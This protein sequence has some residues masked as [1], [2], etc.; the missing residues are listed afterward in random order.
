MG[1]NIRDTA[2][3]MREEFRYHTVYHALQKLRDPSPPE[4]NPEEVVRMPIE[5]S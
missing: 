5:L 1:V 4:N 3:L 2:N